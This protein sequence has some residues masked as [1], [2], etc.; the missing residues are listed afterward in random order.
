MLP[1]PYVPP[2]VVD[3]A[4]L[5]K[6]WAA[7]K[8]TDHSLWLVIGLARFAGLRRE[9]ITHCRGGWIEEQNG[10]VSIALRDRPEEKWWTKTGKPYRAQV[11]NA[12]LAEWLIAV[13]DFEPLDKLVVPDPASGFDRGRWFERAPQQWLHD[14]GVASLKPLHR[15]RGLYAD[16]I[17]R[18]TSDAV[19]ARLAAVRA[20]QQ[21][22]GHTSSE[23]TEKHYLDPNAVR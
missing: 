15:L 11:I 1:E 14:N 9:E 20:A 22:L 5:L 8:E 2:S 19:T 7:L 18:L 23:T 12:E 21:N 17:A 16:H 4:E 13:R 10:V 6:A 3:D